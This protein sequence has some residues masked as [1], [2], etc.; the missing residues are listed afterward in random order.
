MAVPQVPEQH[1]NAA[2]AEELGLGVTLPI[3]DLT[4]AALRAAVEEVAA[5]DAL[6]NRLSR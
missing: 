3:G 4:S 5:A 2:R 6:E 1:A